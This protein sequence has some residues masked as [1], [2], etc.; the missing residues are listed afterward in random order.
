MTLTTTKQ[1]IESDMNNPNWN[2]QTSMNASWPQAERALASNA[3]A[4]P[5]MQTIIKHFRTVLFQSFSKNRPA[6]ARAAVTVNGIISL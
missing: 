1:E 6:R 4:T 2:K 3:A 5:Y